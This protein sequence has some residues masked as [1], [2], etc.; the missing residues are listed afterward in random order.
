MDQYYVYMII[1]NINNKKYI[2]K[3][4]GKIN[5]SYLGSGDN[6]KKA[7][8]KYGKENFSKVILY[9]AENEEDAFNKEK[10]LIALNNAT[11]DPMFYNIHEGGQGGNTWVGMSE[12]Q[13]EK[14][15]KKFSEMNQGEKNGMYGKHHS[16]ETRKLLSELA[17]NRD[18][19]SYRSLKFREKMSSIT[20]G[21]KNGM[22]GKRHTEESKKK[23]SENSVGKTAGKKNGMYGK[24][25]DNAINGKRIEM[26]DENHQLIRTFNA[27]TAAL[28]FLG[29]KGHTQLD[30]AIKEQTLYKGY[31]WKQKN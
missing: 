28:Q 13:K 4:Y 30:K 27:K 19:S 22:Y 17:Y 23:M 7:I 14:L 21:E 24:K 9:I 8:K 1:N 31:Y 12:E 20:K 18:Q 2:G 25:G 11:K 16:P 29:L 6:I 26:Y 3:H 15:R 5:D 10:E